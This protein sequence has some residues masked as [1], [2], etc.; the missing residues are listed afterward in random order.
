MGELGRGCRDIRAA[1][2]SSRMCRTATGFILGYKKNYLGVTV[3]NS[4][5]SLSVGSLA[6]G[7][8]EDDCR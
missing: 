4:Q 5:Y 2:C 1:P 7:D 3:R 6:C 8:L